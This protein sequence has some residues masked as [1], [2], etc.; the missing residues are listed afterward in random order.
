MGRDPRI[1]LFLVGRIE[2]IVQRNCIGKK[3]G[4]GLEMYQ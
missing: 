3:P 2:L 1:P 4:I